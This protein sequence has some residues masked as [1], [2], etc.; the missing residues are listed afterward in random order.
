M[1]RASFLALALCLVGFAAQLPAVQPKGPPPKPQ[2][3]YQNFRE[4]M[5]EG[6]YDVAANFL[7][8]FLDSNPSDADFLDIE[9]KYGTTAFTML[10]T[11][12]KW[13]DDAATE[14]KARANVEEA[15]KRAR[16]AS[17]KLLRDPARVAKY[18]ANLGATYEE[19][20]FAELELKR[21]GDFAVPFMVRELSIT[22]DNNVYAGILQAIKQQEGHAISGWVAALDGLKAPQ[23]AGVVTAIAARDDVL[24]LQTFA[25]SDLAP[26]LWRVLGETEN[27]VNRGLHRMAEEMMQKLHPGVKFNFQ[28]P[29]ARL[30]AAARTFYDHTARFAATRT[31]PDG[32]PAMVPIWGGRQVRQCPED[33]RVPIG[34][35]EE[36]TGFAMPAGRWAE[37]DYEPRRR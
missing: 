15:V 12:P 2:V 25:Q 26:F 18:I 4:L 35:A 32:S 5:A 37:P 7:Q 23:Q 9:K 21:M 3:V 27:D 19:R 34:Q 11:V 31:N 33:R 24:K 10:R 1:R 14:K 8:S 13:S 30:V 36:Y 16:A 28:Q 17:E 6:R 20:V 29:E 22:R